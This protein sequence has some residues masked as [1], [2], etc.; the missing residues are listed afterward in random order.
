MQVASL[1]ANFA[2]RKNEEW[3]KLFHVYLFLLLIQFNTGSKFR[4]GHVK[5]EVQNK[6][7]AE[8]FV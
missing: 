5:G 4:R 3:L 2:M 8:T 7:V 6:H 1:F